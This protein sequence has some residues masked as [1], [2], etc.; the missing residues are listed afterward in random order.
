MTSANFS[1]STDVYVAEETMKQAFVSIIY[2]LGA[3]LVA[4]IFEAVAVA[5]EP[6]LVLLWPNGAPGAKG[7]APT[8]QPRVT[9]FP[10]PADVSVK[11]AVVICP[12]GGYG[13][14]ATAHEGR[15]IAA[16]FNQRGITALML[17]YRLG[18]KGYKH[19]APLLDAQRAIRYVRSQAETLGYATDKIGLLGFSAGGHLA[20]TAG[21]HFDD[22]NKEAQDPIDKYSSRP[23]FLMLGYPVITMGDKTHGGSKRNLLGESPDP[24]LVELL[25]NEKQVTPQT[26]PTFLFHTTE[27]TVVLPENSVLFYLA[28]RQAKVPA[29]LHIYEKGKHGVGLAAQDPILSSWSERLEDWLRVREILPKK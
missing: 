11:A 15:D 16:W 23:D 8:D 29:E 18:S 6:K 27:D 1:Q 28:L 26:P 20:S 22:G 17:E 25:S 14:L 21:T 19:P 2:C 5:E 10:A 24:A 9:V 4:G 7:T 3:L 12:G 13:T